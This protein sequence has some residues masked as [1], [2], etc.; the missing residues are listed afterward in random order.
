MNYQINYAV[1]KSLDLMSRA[2]SAPHKPWAVRLEPRAVSGGS[3]TRWDIGIEP[4]EKFAE[5]KLNPRRQ[6]ILEWLAHVQ[7]AGASYPQREFRLVYNEGGGPILIALNHLIRIGQEARNGTHFEELLRGEP[8]KDSGEIATL[9]GAEAFGLLRRTKLKNIP[10][11]VLESN[12]SL[13][14]RLLAGDKGGKRLVEFLF[15]K[16]AKAVPQRATLPVNELIDEAT[17]EGII[18]QP[19][20][21]FD[22]RDLSAEAADAL[23]VLRSCRTGLPIEVV[24]E[25]VGCGREQIEQQLAPLVGGVLV[26][27]DGLW[28]AGPVPGRITRHDGQSVICRA[29]D[30]LLRF[31]DRHKKD[32]VAITQ[33]Q[34]AADLAK[35]CG[36]AH[37][38]T[39][40]V[41]FPIL[42]KVLKRL[43]SK[44]LVL[45]MARLSVDA[46]RRAQHRDQK[47]LEAEAQ[48]LICGVAWVYQRVGRLEK[49]RVAAEESQKLAKMVS[50]DVNLA[51]CVKCL[52][53]LC[54]MEAE[55]VSA[56]PQRDAKI[57]ESIA[58][59]EEAIDR[60]SQLT[61]FGPTDPEVGDCYSLLGRTY[62]EAGQLS[63]AEGAIRKA[64]E[65]I[66]DRDSKDYLDLVILSGDLEVAKS[67]KSAAASY[68]DQALNLPPSRDPE[69]TEMRARAHLKRGRNNVAR[70]ETEAAKKDFATAVEIW[71]KLGER[72]F[73]AEAEWEHIRLNGNLPHDALQQLEREPS[74]IRVAA[75]AIHK[76]RLAPYEGRRVAQRARF[77][78]NYWK[79]RIKE[80]GL[81]V[82]SKVVEW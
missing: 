43:G 52:G 8:I 59:L 63:K 71:E 66:T 30:S 22:P 37:P 23:Y 60:F 54:R 62:L 10:E 18:L 17:K 67:D 73:S 82:A 34:N 46:S 78:R 31:V 48:S 1:F 77:D 26:S 32:P 40:A 75:V 70:R 13:R 55:A 7:E 61:R 5:A 29:L 33:I 14:A 74:N 69:I 4:P 27:D 16:L 20:P 56:G 44:Q 51:F 81:R 38:E 19:P 39:V 9:L 57:H 28:S 25:A 53:R 12:I 50:M 80:A 47:I 45:D 3:L 58:L 76:E 2:L 15:N 41:V 35:Q 21:D 24:A 11:N 6:E 49:A 64:Y 79:E 72:E 36:D 42:D 68:Y 65:L